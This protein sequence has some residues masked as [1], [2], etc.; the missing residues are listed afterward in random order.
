MIDAPC[1]FWPPELNLFAPLEIVVCERVTG[2]PPVVT[3]T[4]VSTD[5]ACT[6]CGLSPLTTK[7]RRDAASMTGVPRIPSPPVA[8]FVFQ[9]GSPD[10][11]SKATTLG[12]ALSDGN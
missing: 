3:S 5:S 12:L 1:W 9:T 2:Q 4:P 6:T 10:V 7:R 11:S 8:T